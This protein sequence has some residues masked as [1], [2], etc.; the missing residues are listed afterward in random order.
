MKRIMLKSVLHLKYL[1]QT[2]KKPFTLQN[3]GQPLICRLTVFI[4]LLCVL[5]D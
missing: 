2:K 4:F 5:V 3:N 1:I